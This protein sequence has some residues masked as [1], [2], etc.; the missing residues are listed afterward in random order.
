MKINPLFEAISE[1]DEKFVIESEKKFAAQKRKETFAKILRPVA[2]T[3]SIVLIFGFALFMW[4]VAQKYK[5]PVKPADSG[6]ASETNVTGEPETGEQTTATDETETPTEAVTEKPDETFEAAAV[7]M[8]SDYYSDDAVSFLFDPYNVSPVFDIAAKLAFDESAADELRDNA[9]HFIY[10]VMREDRAG[11]LLFYN[12]EYHWGLSTGDA[13]KPYILLLDHYLDAAKKAAEGLSADCVQTRA[14]RTYSLLCASGYEFYTP[15]NTESRIVDIYERALTLYNAVWG[16]KPITDGNTVKITKPYPAELKAAINEYWGDT[17]RAFY[18]SE[19]LTEK[20]IKTLSDNVFDFDVTNLLIRPTKYFIIV[21]GTVYMTPANE[22]DSDAK[23]YFFSSFVKY[24]YY[25]ATKSEYLYV[26]RKDGSGMEYSDRLSIKS[27]SGKRIAGGEL[28]D[29]IITERGDA[30]IERMFYL[31]SNSSDTSFKSKNVICKT[32]TSLM[33]EE[34]L[35]YIASHYFTEESESLRA[36]MSS[37]FADYLDDEALEIFLYS[38][39]EKPDCMAD[40]RAYFGISGNNCAGWLQDYLDGAKKAAKKLYEEEV[41][42]YYPVTYSLLKNTGFKDYRSGAYDIAYRSRE[43]I[44]KLGALYDAVTHGAGLTD[45]TSLRYG[46]TKEG[47]VEEKITGWPDEIKGLIEKYKDDPKSGFNMTYICTQRQGLKTVGEWYTYFSDIMPEKDV[48]AFIGNGNA[49]FMIDDDGTV[50]TRNEKVEIMWPMEIYERTARVVEEKD[51]YTVIGFLV[52]CPG[53]MADEVREFTI[54]VKNGKN[55]LYIDGGSFIDVFMKKNITR[56]DAASALSD[57]LRA[58][59]L[60]YNGQ[61]DASVYRSANSLDLSEDYPILYKSKDDLPA[62]LTRSPF[63]GY[64]PDVFPTYSCYPFFQSVHFDDF[65]SEQIYDEMM[66][67]GGC[68]KHVKDQF[69]FVT[70]SL[71]TVTNTAKACE[72][73][74]Y[75]IYNIEKALKNV[76]VKGDKMT[77]SLD[78]VREENGKSTNKTYTFEF[79]YKDGNAVLT[80]GTFVTECLKK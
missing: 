43:L 61:T 42:K 56:Y 11:D 65:V 5:D 70:P 66:K 68:F 47:D 23:S 3:A 29:E 71:V 48:R 13:G 69:C 72:N 16:G 74:D 75:S 49:L 77:A 76:S 12:G 55:G 22:S 17:D 20:S 28:A 67:D 64:E 38:N 59:A 62:D 36:A 27:A 78:F 15:G 80:G 52:D 9:A 40:Y 44:L 53:N 51:G 60:I 50:Y 25:D 39:T 31:I 4:M 18:T 46:I 7:K 58:H 30:A 21:D 41:S 63:Y 19:T 24:Q 1:T 33:K 32:V 10:D 6:T 8:L 57:I 73:G 34:T 14:Y 45:E 35:S 26:C 2:A 79:E 54:H 37:V